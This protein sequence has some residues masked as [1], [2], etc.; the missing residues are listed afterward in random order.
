MKICSIS[1]KVSNSA[2]NDMLLFTYIN[3]KQY[4]LHKKEWT[5]KKIVLNGLLCAK[6]LEQ[7]LVHVTVM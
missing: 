5:N 7:C 1:F 2:D 4:H 3:A 6:H